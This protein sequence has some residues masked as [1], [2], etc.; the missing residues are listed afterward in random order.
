MC[1]PSAQ[2]VATWLAC[3]LCVPWCKIAAR[4]NFLRWIT[5]FLYKL[6]ELFYDITLHTLCKGILCHD[7]GPMVVLRLLNSS[8][9]ARYSFRRNMFGLLCKTMWCRFPWGRYAS[10]DTSGIT[11]TCIIHCM[12]KTHVRKQ[13]KFL[14]PSVSSCK[15]RPP[16]TNRKCT[17]GNEIKGPA[18]P[19]CTLTK[20]NFI[21]LLNFSHSC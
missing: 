4:R 15:S 17:W 21:L 2:T 1:R 20:L 5:I 16:A 7:F 13:T 12:C 10:K 18:W 8:A 6:C 3:S 9:H 11:D 19:G 14:D